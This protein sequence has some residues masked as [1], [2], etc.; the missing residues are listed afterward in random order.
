MEWRRGDLN[1]REPD[2]VG[3]RG[4]VTWWVTRTGMRSGAI[5][6]AQRGVGGGKEGA[7]LSAGKR[8]VG[9]GEG[10]GG[11]K[12]LGEMETADEVGEWVREVLGQSEL[13][14]VAT[15]VDEIVDCFK[16]ND[17]C[18]RDALLL[19]MVPLRVQGLGSGV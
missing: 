15:R 6:V 17:V 7:R 19:T 10:E 12:T 11:G 16:R 5:A 13:A 14:S 3:E 9:A 2:G 1:K 18:G 4:D 8:G